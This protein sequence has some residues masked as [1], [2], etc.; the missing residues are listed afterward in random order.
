MK[1]R[2]FTKCLLLKF[3]VVTLE[4]GSMV[5]SRQYVAALAERLE[6]P[7]IPLEV[8]REITEKVIDFI[9]PRAISYEDQVGVFIKMLFSNKAK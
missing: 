8:V 7:D 6:Q 1:N 2:K 4:T 3:L 5:V 9:L